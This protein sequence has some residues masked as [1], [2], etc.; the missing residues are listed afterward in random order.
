MQQLYGEPQSGPC[1]SGTGGLYCRLRQVTMLPEE[2]GE[3]MQI[4]HYTNGEKYEP[5]HDFFHDS[6][7]SD[8]ATGG[9]RIATVLM[10]L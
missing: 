10:Y 8:P 1:E 2:N 3:G 9:Q 6:V 5:H 4:L 7:N